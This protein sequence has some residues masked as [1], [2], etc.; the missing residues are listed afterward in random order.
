MGMAL[1]GSS[2]T[3]AQEVS[4][5]CVVGPPC[6]RPLEDRTTPAVGGWAA[7]VNQVRQLSQSLSHG[8][9]TGMG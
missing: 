8:E 6:K 5:C 7:I 9:K 1:E 3:E 4:L 2:P